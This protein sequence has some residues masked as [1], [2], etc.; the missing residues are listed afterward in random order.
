MKLCFLCSFNCSAARVGASGWPLPSTFSVYFTKLFARAD[1]KCMQW[2]LLWIDLMIFQQQFILPLYRSHGRSPPNRLPCRLLRAPHDYPHF[3]VGRGHL[4]RR[5]IIHAQL[6]GFR[7]TALRL[8]TSSTG[9]TFSHCKR[10]RKWWAEEEENARN[11]DCYFLLIRW[12]LWLTDWPIDW[13]I[14]CCVMDSIKNVFLRFLFSRECKSDL[15][16]LLSGC[17]WKNAAHSVHWPS[18]CGALVWCF[19]AC[20]ATCF[21]TGMTCS[22]LCLWSVCC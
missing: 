12:I 10:I 5:D 14:D 8:R 9:Q 13:L 6:R 16:S 22:W 7:C 4:R 11:P 18:W 15:S 19:S 3:R 21:Q 17:R 1:N 20:S 2:H